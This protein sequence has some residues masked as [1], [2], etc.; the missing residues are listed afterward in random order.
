MEMFSSHT[1]PC[2]FVPC[3]FIALCPPWRPFV[4]SHRLCVLHVTPSVFP[5]L[6]LRISHGTSA[7][8]MFSSF[9]LITSH[10]NLGR[11]EFV[12]THMNLPNHIDKTT[13]SEP[14]CFSQ[15]RKKYAHLLSRGSLYALHSYNLI[16]SPPPPVS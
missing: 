5:D 15:K 16:C 4:H 2:L 7:A 9:V 11:R 13:S 14:L 8:Q 10:S 6:R 3:C 1:W 12:S